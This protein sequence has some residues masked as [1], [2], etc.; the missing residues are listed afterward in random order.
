MG[1]ATGH[2]A[3]PTIAARAPRGPAMPSQALLAQAQEAA[4]QLAQLVGKHLQMCYVR[5]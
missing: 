4:A 1:D 2:I 3:E 5:A